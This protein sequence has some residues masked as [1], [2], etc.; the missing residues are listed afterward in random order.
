M[1]MGGDRDESLRGR[2]GME[3]KLTGMGEVG[4]NYFVSPCTPLERASTLADGCSVG[5]AAPQN[6]PTRTV[7]LTW[8]RIETSESMYRSRTTEAGK[9]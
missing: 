2:V 9:I 7:L 1:G 3:T 4:C 6:R 8:V 5:D